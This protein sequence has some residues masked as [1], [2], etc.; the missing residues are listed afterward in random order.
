MPKTYIQWPKGRVHSVTYNGLIMISF[1]MV[2]HRSF[3]FS[4]AH[5]FLFI[6]VWSLA[7]LRKVRT[8]V[9]I[10]AHTKN[11]L[12][13]CH[14]VQFWD[15]SLKQNLGV[16]GRPEQHVLQ[17]WSIPWNNQGRWQVVCAEYTFYFQA[18]LSSIA[19]AFYVILSGLSI[20]CTCT[21][22]TGCHLTYDIWRHVNNL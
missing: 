5:Q 4:V 20:G 11:W 13:P 21:F 7:K 18:N 14:I 2:R 3:A 10:S 1:I 8:M 12:D 22:V 16:I 15:L 6:P 19:S 17:H 9:A